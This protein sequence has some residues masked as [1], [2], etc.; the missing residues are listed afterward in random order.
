MEIL[1]KKNLILKIAVLSMV[2]KLIYYYCF[3]IFQYL[4][5][6]KLTIKDHTKDYSKYKVDDLKSEL[7]KRGI[8]FSKNARKNDLLD[9]LSNEHAKWA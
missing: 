2:G 8:S 1:I 3:K 6:N 5:D 9:L 4:S 7:K